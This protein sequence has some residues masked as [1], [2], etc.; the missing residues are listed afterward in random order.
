MN[1][2]ENAL[3][4]SSYANELQKDKP[5]NERLEFLGDAVLELLVSEYIYK[6]FSDLSEGEMTKL[7]ANIV[8][9]QSLSQLAS[10]LGLGELLI[11]GKGE[12]SSGGRKRDSILADLFEAVLG[13][14]FLDGG[15]EKAKTYLISLLGDTIHEMRDKIKTSDCKTTLQEY[16]QKTSKEPLEYKIVDEKGPDHEK[17]FFSEVKHRGKVLGRGTGRTKKEAEQNAAMS[18]LKKI[19]ILGSVK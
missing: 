15:F 13:A 17:L 11:L 6:N 19:G 4:H 5:D 2:L 9:E 10:N 3:T 16:V 14:V 12:D 7:R 8:C 18:A 1:L